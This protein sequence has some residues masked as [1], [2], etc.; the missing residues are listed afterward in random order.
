MIWVGSG[1]LVVDIGTGILLSYGVLSN[2]PSHDSYRREVVP[3]GQTRPPNR[4]T[5]H[6]H[7]CWESERGEG[8]HGWLAPGTHHDSRQ[9]EIHWDALAALRT[10][11]TRSCRSYESALSV[12]EAYETQVSEMDTRTTSSSWPKTPF[13]HST[14]PFTTSKLPSTTIQTIKHFLHITKANN[15]HHDELTSHLHNKLP[16]C[17]SHHHR[18]S[19]SFKIV[20]LSHSR[21]E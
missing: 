17:L 5:P 20:A 3:E 12:P 19:A 13:K 8:Q 21:T 18:S 10:K 16:R 14:A 4:F 11:G 2:T 1:V 15:H 9:G 7:R 6:P